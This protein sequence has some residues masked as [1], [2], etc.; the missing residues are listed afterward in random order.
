[1]YTVLR[2]K[3]FDAWL[4]NLKDAKG[5]ARIIA[6]IRSAEYGNLGDVQSVGGGISELRIHFGPGYRVYF[7]QRGKLL[8][9]LLIG[10]D[11]SSQK[12]DI[13]KARTL[14]ERLED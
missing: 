6:R 8:I 13:K 14:V 3:E 9:L 7:T 5:K 2:S 4:A 1:M 11:K 12:R 10:G